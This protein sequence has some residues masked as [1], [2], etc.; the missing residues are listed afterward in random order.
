MTATIDGIDITGA[1]SL[2]RG[3]ILRW[4]TIKGHPPLV[5]EFRFA[6]SRRWRF[7]FANLEARVGIE[8]DGG[9]WRGRRG[10]HSSG[11][12]I[13]RDREKDFAATVQGGWTVIRLTAA[14]AKDR[15]VLT[16]LAGFIRSRI[17]S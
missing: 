11:F 4:C 10:G 3:F 17:Q 7:D 13:S 14:M 15:G 9:I 1:S 8:I 12:G 16:A 2:E 5:R 6:E